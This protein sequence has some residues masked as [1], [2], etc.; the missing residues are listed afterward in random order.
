MRWEAGI[1]QGLKWRKGRLETSLDRG[2]GSGCGKVEERWREAVSG[3][4]GTLDTSAILMLEAS[5]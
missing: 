5:M 3:N 4:L 1:V 2:G